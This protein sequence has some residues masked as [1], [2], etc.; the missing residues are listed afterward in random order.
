MLCDSLILQRIVNFDYFKKSGTK[1]WLA[2]SISNFQRKNRQFFPSFFQVFLISKLFV[3]WFWGKY[4]ENIIC[5]FGYGGG[6]LKERESMVMYL[7]ITS[8]ITHKEPRLF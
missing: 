1:N 4:H 3:G 7:Y 6:V 8:L 5:Q 2:L